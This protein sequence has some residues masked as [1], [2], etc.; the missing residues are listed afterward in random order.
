MSTWPV[1]N[2]LKSKFEDDVELRCRGEDATCLLSS[3]E[4][5][6]LPELPFD[7]RK[8]NTTEKV[9]RQTAWCFR[10]IRNLQKKRNREEIKLSDLDA[11]EYQYAKGFCIKVAQTEMKKETGYEKR[12]ESLGLFEDDEGFLRCIG[13]IG[14]AKIPFQTK[15][16][17][18]LPRNSFFTEL[19]IN[20]AH[21]KVFHNGVKETLAEV[22]SACWVV[23]GRQLVKKVL[24]RCFLCRIL[25]G[26]AYPAPITC[27]L[28]D[29]RV[30]PG[31]AFDTIGVDFCGPVYVRDIYKKDGGMHKAYVVVT[32]CATSRMVH[33]EISPDLSTAAYLRSQKRFISRRG[34]PRLGVSDNGKAFKG[35]ELRQFNTK[36][37]IKWR[38]NIARAPWW[39]GMFERMVR[40]TKRCLLK[41]VGKQKL[42]YEELSTVLT[43]VE[44][45]LNNRP[46]MYIDEE[47]KKIKTRYS[48]HLIYSVDEGRFRKIL[49]SHMF[50]LPKKIPQLHLV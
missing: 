21:E 23:K 28:P 37:G 15:F 2:D 36:H 39:G 24:K 14:K 5:V 32:T 31:R 38:F 46:L 40:S 8:Y 44:A 6:C 13:R 9:V 12:S 19:M 7:I 50:S 29:F 16:P 27:D 20:E 45:V 34:Y 33:L 49:E 48:L 4:T 30:D 22:R 47:I 42:T 43:E 17:I 18:L 1:T 35:K 25:E 10:F 26:L 3:S 11:E 41:A